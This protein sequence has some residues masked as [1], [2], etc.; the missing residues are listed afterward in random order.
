[1]EEITYW[2]IKNTVTGL[3]YRGKGTNR[4]GKHFNQVSIYRIR[5]MAQTF[6]EKINA[7]NIGDE[8]AIVV[9]ITIAELD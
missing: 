6:C 9:P 2:A 3:Y 7:L 8:R 1:M 5:G 4:W